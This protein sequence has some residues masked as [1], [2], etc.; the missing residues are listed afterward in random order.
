MG[1]RKFWLVTPPRLG[2]VTVADE[3]ALNHKLLKNVGARC[4]ARLQAGLQSNE[5]GKGDS[6]K[7]AKEN[8]RCAAC[9]LGQP[10]D[11]VSRLE[12]RGSHLAALPGPGTYRLDFPQA[13]IG[14]GRRGSCLKKRPTRRNHDVQWHGCGHRESNDGSP[15]RYSK[16]LGR[17]HF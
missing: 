16:S 5:A 12:F 7:S 6:M 3:A 14:A 8:R 4:A 10:N 13:A 2:I 9:T 17:S 15:H 11:G 1:A